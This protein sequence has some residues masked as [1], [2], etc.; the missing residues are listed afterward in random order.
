MSEGNLQTY[1]KTEAK[2]HNILWRKMKFEGR[3][4][5]P[6][7]LVAWGGKLML[8]ELK[9]PN[10]NGVLSKIQEREIQKFKDAGVDVRVVEK[11]EE[12]DGIIKEIAGS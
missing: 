6:D 8:V 3:R 2:A 9:N 1:F 10:G 11:R 12:V 7:V 4:G 5:C